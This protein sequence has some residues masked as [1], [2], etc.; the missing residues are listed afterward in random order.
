MST[1]D[2]RTGHEVFGTWSQF[3]NVY[4]CQF[5]IGFSY[6]TEGVPITISENRTGAKWEVF[7]TNL[8]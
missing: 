3:A 1:T 2:S 6:W 5:E 8:G 4:V 7:L